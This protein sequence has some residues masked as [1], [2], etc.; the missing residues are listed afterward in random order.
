PISR[1]G[2]DAADEPGEERLDDPEGSVP[3]GHVGLAATALERAYDVA[4]HVLGLDDGSAE[5]RVREDGALR[6]AL[7]LDEARVDGLAADPGAAHEERDPRMPLD[8]RRRR[9]L[10]RLAVGD[11]A[12][13]VLAVE[14]LG[15]GAKPLLAAGDEH[16]PE[17]ARRELAGDRRADPARGAGDD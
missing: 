2:G 17:P 9:P 6:E 16:A 5:E 14:F 13:L 12:E 15:E 4:R 11:V 3:A 8:D 10:D 7:R 1:A